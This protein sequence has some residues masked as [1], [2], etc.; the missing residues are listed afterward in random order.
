[1][2]KKTVNCRIGSLEELN[3]IDLQSLTFQEQIMNIVSQSDSYAELQEKLLEIYPDVDTRDLEA[4]L[5]KNIANAEILAK[6]EIEE[7][8]PNG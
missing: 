8:N 3:K 7:E 4:L 5:Y 6:A 1:M 2:G